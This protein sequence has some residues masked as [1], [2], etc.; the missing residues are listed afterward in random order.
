MVDGLV[1]RAHEFAEILLV[2]EELVLL[3]ARL[4]DA[5]AFRNRE[6]KVLARPRRLHVDEIRALTCRQAVRIDFVPT[7]MAGGPTV[8]TSIA[9][10]IKVVMALPLVVAHLSTSSVTPLTCPC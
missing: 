9:A 6:E 3:V 7:L 5:L 1:Q 10:T 2:Q 4:I 8:P